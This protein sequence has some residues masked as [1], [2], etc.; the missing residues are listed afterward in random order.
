[1]APASVKRNV[2]FN[3]IGQFYITIIGIVVLPLFLGQMGAEAYGLIGFFALLQAWMSLLDLGMSP[4]LGRE[5]A[6]LKS[7]SS[8]HWRLLTVVNSL[9]IVFIFIAVALGGTILIGRDWIASDWLKFD[10]LEPETVTTVLSVIAITVSLRWVSSLNRSGINAYEAQVWMNSVDLV[11]NTLRYPVALLLVMFTDGSVEA[12]F[13]FQL[14]LVVAEF[15]VIRIKFRQLLPKRS[16][17]VYLFSLDELKRIAPFA[18]GI[19]YTGAI[20]VLLTQLDKLLLSKFL[21]LSEYGYFALVGTAVGG[22]GV[23]GGPISRAVLPRMT[24]LLA[25]GQEQEMLQLYRKSSRLVVALVTPTAITMA[26]YPWLVVHA[27]TGDREAAEWAS[28]IL[29]LFALG[30]GLMAILSYQYFLQYAHGDLKYHIRWNT[31]SVIIN[32][33]LIFYA[34]ANFGALG[35]AWVWLGFR[36]FSF[37]VWMPFIH[38]R[39]APG[40][41]LRWLVRDV[42]PTV[43]VTIAVVGVSYLALRG[44]NIYEMGRFYQFGVLGITA[45]LAIVLAFAMA[46]PQKVRGIFRG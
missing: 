1:M 37:C 40:L 44:I 22:I 32:V 20:W 33:P 10:S 46:A 30:A 8:E 2:I 18:L 5:V 4:T 13:F 24:G 12:Y 15:T 39:F 41:H 26:V 17:R 6:R 36:L 27:W 34:A 11:V 42:L 31:F 25:K 45:G 23:M 16:A 43:I 21:P 29:R 38:S 35:V 3:Y 28:E 9:E 19:G 7:N 14:A